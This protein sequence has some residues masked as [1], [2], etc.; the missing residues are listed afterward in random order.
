LAPSPSTRPGIQSGTNGRMREQVN[1]DTIPGYQAEMAHREC[2]MAIG[3]PGLG[4]GLVATSHLGFAGAF[5][6]GSRKE[7][8]ENSR[9]SVI[10]E[11]C[12]RQSAHQRRVAKSSLIRL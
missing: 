12:N 1:C 5:G 3:L 11:V 2:S 8:E 4:Q 7:K 6:R 10:L 9:T